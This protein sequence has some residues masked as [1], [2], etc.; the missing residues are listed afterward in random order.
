[1]RRKLAAWRSFENNLQ[2]TVTSRKHGWNLPNH[3]PESSKS[4]SAASKLETPLSTFTNQPASEHDICALHGVIKALFDDDYHSGLTQKAH[5]AKLPLLSQFM[6]V[7]CRISTYMFVVS[8]CQ[9]SACDFCGD[10]PSRCGPLAQS[11]S[12][13]EILLCHGRTSQIQR[14]T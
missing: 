10:E 8:R 1:M 7:H 11:L 2:N 3:Q 14:I 9:D 6:K 5:L 4:A 13:H 12:L